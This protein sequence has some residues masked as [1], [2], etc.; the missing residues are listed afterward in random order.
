MQ[1]ILQYVLDMPSK[2]YDLSKL[3]W[4]VSTGFVVYRGQSGSSESKPGIPRKGFN[5]YEISMGFG[6]PISTSR[7]LTPRILQF[8]FPAPG[9]I[10][11]IHVMPGVRYVSIKDAVGG[12][13]EDP[14]V[15][16][17]LKKS[18]PE[19]HA[20]K[21]KSASDL[22]G[23]FNDIIDREDEVLL[24]LKGTEF[25]NA[26]GGLETWDGKEGDLVFSMG[27]D[28]KGKPR[29]F[30]NDKG[31]YV[32]SLPVKIY[33]TYLL[34]KAAGGRRGSRGRTLRS[35]SKRRNKNGRGLADKPKTRR[36]RG[37]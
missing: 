15:F 11:K 20:Y 21:E 37:S 23:L 4:V 35:T 22:L 8:S 3:P 17:V 12:S 6:A 34:P 28:T 5:P 10:F 33:E 7:Q 24:D 31:Q 30:Q 1:D 26:G 13:I 18:L 29:R 9:R 14:E 19:G 36:N 25:R 16:E 32:T 27:K 2:K